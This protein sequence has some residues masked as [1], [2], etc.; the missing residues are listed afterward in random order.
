[1]LTSPIAIGW[2]HAGQILLAM[3]EIIHEEKLISS[4]PIYRRMK[5]NGNTIALD[6]DSV[7]GGLVAHGEKLV[8]F[9]IAG[10]DRKFVDA[11][12]VIS[13]SSVIVTAPPTAPPPVAVRY[14]FAQAVLPVPNLY[15]KEGLPAS[16]FRTDDW[17]VE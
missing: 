9:Q 14:G 8:G 7:G 15:N 10:S 17:A 11:D 6:F 1:M 2:P 12:A 5:V 4:G 13:G 16:P 3:D